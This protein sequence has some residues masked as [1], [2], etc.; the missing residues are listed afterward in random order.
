MI[1]GFSD[2]LYRYTNRYTIIP[3]AILFLLHVFV[4]LPSESSVDRIVGTGGGIL[5]YFRWFIYSP[6]DFYRV[7]TDIGAEGRQA[8]ID[9]RIIKA[10]IFIFSIGSFFTLVTGALLR[11][12]TADSNP[13]RRLNVIGF[14][15]AF[16]D[17]VENH[18]QMVL[19]SLYPERYDG[20]VIVITTFTAVKWITL[21]AA[22]LIFFFAAA[23]AIISLFR[24]APEKPN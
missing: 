11:L 18:V 7:L 5:Q 16:C 13:L 6:D 4:I 15:P 20:I 23:A 17:V 3:V 2:W 22:I 12:A 24:R 19:V 10:N 21:F 14:M 9:H 8:F 1:R